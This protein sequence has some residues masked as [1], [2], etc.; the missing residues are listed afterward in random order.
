MI[1]MGDGILQATREHYGNKVFQLPSVLTWVTKNFSTPGRKRR[2]DRTLLGGPFE[3][4]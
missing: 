2:D 1:G 3:I 4:L